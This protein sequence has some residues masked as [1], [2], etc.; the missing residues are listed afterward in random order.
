[1]LLDYGESKVYPEVFQW[2]QFIALMVASPNYLINNLWQFSV[3][4]GLL[5]ASS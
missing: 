1:M 4:F 5:F 3:Y 2:F